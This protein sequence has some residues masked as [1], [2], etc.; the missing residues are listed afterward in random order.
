M[1][2]S[3]TLRVAVSAALL[4]AQAPAWA[5][6]AEP[7]PRGVPPGADADPVV[8]VLGKA[9]RPVNG[10]WSEGVP[11]WF[12]SSKSD[13]GGVY[14][15]PYLSVGYGL[16]HWIWLG[17]DLNAI[18]TLEFAQVYT[19]A[20]ASSPIL[21]FAF[22]VRD[23]YSY[24][25]T[26]LD[27]QVTF[28]A[29]DVTRP[30]SNARYWAWE[31]EGVAVAPL[32]HSAILV[33]YV[34]VGMIDVP[35]DRYVYEE[36]YRAIVASAFF[37]G[38]RAAVVL[39]VLGE[40]ALKIGVLSELITST[41]RS[42]SVFRKGPAAALQLTDHVEMLGTLSVALASPD[43][44]GLALGAYGVAGFRYRW[45]TGE[46]APKWPWKGLRVP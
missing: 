15:K 9:P 29:D 45:A 40:D 26:F 19:G 1:G 20:R 42:R 25:K 41:G 44:L 5:L 35:E 3:I 33:N 28:V 17:A 43:R 22:G 31:A 21:D 36:S 27:P 16:P 4:T 18:T 13:V 12:V 32:P 24:G 10:Y 8:E 6:P 38:F 2:R 11:R 7:G 23:T 34:A 46:S 39:R 14:V 37:R 30:G